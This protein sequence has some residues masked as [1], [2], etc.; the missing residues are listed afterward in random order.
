MKKRRSSAL[1][2]PTPQRVSARVS[3]RTY[4]TA[5]ASRLI[6]TPA[7]GLVSLDPSGGS[8][9]A[10]LKKRPTSEVRTSGAA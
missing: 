5:Y 4:G 10:G 8:S 6:V 9:G 1:A 2:Q 7:F 3:P